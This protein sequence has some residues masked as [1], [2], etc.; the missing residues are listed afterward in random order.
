MVSRKKK[1]NWIHTKFD[2]Q[3]VHIDTEKRIL[4]YNR[5][6]YMIR[7]EGVKGKILHIYGYTEEAKQ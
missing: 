3:G 4:S 1:Q 6:K 5:E 7:L 2:G